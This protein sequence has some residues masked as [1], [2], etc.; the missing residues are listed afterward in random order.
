[1]PLEI[2]FATAMSSAVPNEIALAS[3][4]GKWNEVGPCGGGIDADPGSRDRVERAAGGA[5]FPRSAF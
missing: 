2:A 4:E 3:I 5:D 1:M